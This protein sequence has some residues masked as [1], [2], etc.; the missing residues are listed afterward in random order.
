MPAKLLVVEDDSST[1][2]ILSTLLEEAGYDVRSC[3][4][5]EEALAVITSDARV[6]IVISDLRLPDGSGLQVLWALKKIRPD[7]ELI[8]STGHASLETALEAINEGAFAYH[9]K[10]LDLDA[11]VHGVRNALR[12]QQ[13]ALENKHLL[14]QLKQSNH[15]LTESNLALEDKNQELERALVAKTQILSTVSHE[16]KTPLVSI[17]GNVDRL[18]AKHQPV[19]PLNEQQLQYLDTVRANSKRLRLLIGDLLD[20]ARIESGTVELTLT[21]FDVLPEIQNI[22]GSMQEQMVKKKMNVVLNIG[23]GLWVRADKLRF[24]QIVDNLLSNA[25]KYSPIG[26]FTTITASETG[27]VVAI[28]VTDIGT[29]ISKAD[30][31]KLFTKFFRADNSSTRAESGTGL[32]LYIVRRLVEI[33][34]GRIWAHSEEG[35]GST[36]TF[37]VPSGCT[38]QMSVKEPGR[39]PIDM[40]ANPVG[41]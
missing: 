5:A 28:G 20:V 3:Q 17:V 34:G 14:D 10:P 9:V 12:Q 41:D 33:Q 18:L 25:C 21:E 26:S 38:D 6:D 39:Q 30:Q 1:R 19:G 31:P 27:G 32:G 37:T 15:K 22:V 24:T 36:F 13:L 23:S 4:S 2:T 11:L 16:L 29:G 7:S 35:I 40:T 8:L